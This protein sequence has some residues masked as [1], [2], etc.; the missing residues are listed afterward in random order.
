[1]HMVVKERQVE[2]GGLDLAASGSKLGTRGFLN[3]SEQGIPSNG[4]D[5]RENKGTESEIIDGEKGL[6][7]DLQSTSRRERGIGDTAPADNE[8][9]STD[10]CDQSMRAASSAS[11]Y[12]QVYTAAYQAA[13]QA[14]FSSRGPDDPSSSAQGTDG[15]VPLNYPP[16]AMFPTMLPI[17][18]PVLPRPIPEQEG[19]QHE[20]RENKYVIPVIPVAYALPGDRVLHRRRRNMDGSTSREDMQ[21]L[22]DN[23]ATLLR[24]LHE[25]DQDRDHREFNIGS[26]DENAAHNNQN[27]RRQQ[28]RRR[29]IHVRLQINMRVLLQAAVLLMVIYQHCPPHRFFVLTAIGTLLYLSSTRIGGILLR[30]I[31]NYFGQNGQREHNGNPGGNSLNENPEGPQ[32]DQRAVDGNQ[33]QAHGVMHEIQGFIAGFIASLLPAANGPLQDQGQMQDVFGANAGGR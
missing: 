10:E 20:L 1:M 29:N 6:S 16:L 15:R 25:R 13:L 11:L 27:R 3:V 30:R 7:D 22:P 18:Q 14:I 5:K 2:Q 32:Q 23:L 9:K 26:Q 4:D 24:A 12:H 19:Q 33:N 31:M 17:P 8:A 21:S 28:P